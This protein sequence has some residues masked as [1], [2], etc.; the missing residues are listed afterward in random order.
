MGDLSASWLQVVPLI[1]RT[2]ERGLP[3]QMPIV[4]LCA[5]PP[6]MAILDQL[7]LLQDRN[8][9]AILGNPV[10]APDLLLSGVEECSVIICLGINID[11]ALLK[12]GTDG[13]EML[14]ADVVMLQR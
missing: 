7:Q 1:I 13:T 12:G 9:A 5:E 14:D 2:R 11:P 10:W 6:T 4:V 8:F 3:F